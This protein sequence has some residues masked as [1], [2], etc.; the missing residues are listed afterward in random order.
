MAKVGRPRGPV[1]WTEERLDALADRLNQYTEETEIPILADFAYKNGILRE[2]LYELARKNVHLA[3]AI[4][5]IMERKQTVLET[6]AL[7]GELN[8]TMAVFSLKQMGWT[9]K[10]ETTLKTIDEN[11]EE[12]GFNFVDAPKKSNE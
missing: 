10:Q 4:K 1:K 8:T 2:Q 3:Y 7:N 11:G 6:G 5:A 9:D 12:T